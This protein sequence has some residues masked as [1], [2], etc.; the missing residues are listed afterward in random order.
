MKRKKIALYDPY[1]DVLGG[2]EKHILSIIE[3]IS[4]NADIEIFWNKNLYKQIQSRLNINFPQDPI[5]INNIFAKGRNIFQKINCLKKYDYFFY[6][7]DGSYFFS[8]AKNNYIFCMIPDK[9]LYKLN[10]FNKLKT[11]NYNFISNSK[12]TNTWLNKW[13]IKSEVIYP[14][15]DT[16]FIQYDLSSIKKEKIILSV[17]R[18]F[19][20][21]HS[22][23]QD[24]L[25]KTFLQLKKTNRLFSDYKLILA[26][27]VKKEDEDYFQ[28]I[29]KL[30]ENNNS[31][32][33]KSNIS[34]K[35][36]LELY[37]KS[38]IFWHI[39]G[40]EVD[41]MKNPE[42]AEHFG[43]SPLEAMA[44]GCITFAYNAGGLRETIENGKNGFL[45]DTTDEL[46]KKT[47]DVIS[48]EALS[49][50]I[51]KAAK[52]DVIKKFNY[53]TFKKNVLSAIYK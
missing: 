42:M 22:K 35:E 9:K 23:R 41:E 53:S 52:L 46:I 30:S 51:I 10:L 33:F 19:K 34:F 14:Y 6:V 7:T 28:S 44:M 48:N 49:N 26:G 20:Q 37:K 32:V 31:I 47:S 36:L 4:D 45:F 13:G 43:L 27:G 38:Q 5:F 2:G 8:F 50:E 12:F 40:F 29:K 15:I 21:L 16:F 39:A 11:S 3:S 24:I 17:G 18:F 25:I 1:L